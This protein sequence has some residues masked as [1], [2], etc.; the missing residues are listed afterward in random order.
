M[1]IAKDQLEGVTQGVEVYRIE[2]LRDYAG[3]TL[4][5]VDTPGLAD[6]KISELQILNQVQGWRDRWYVLR[7]VTIRQFYTDAAIAN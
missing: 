7:S 3:A 6:P 5:I 1:G 4:Y 2:N